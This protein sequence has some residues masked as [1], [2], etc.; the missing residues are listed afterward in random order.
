MITTASGLQYEVIKEGI[1]EKPG[2]NDK[3]T[4]HYH[5]TLPDGTVFDSSVDRNEPATFPVSG[6][7]A[8]WV[9]GLQLM[10][11]GSK[12]KFIIPANLAYGSRGAGGQIGP[13]QVLHFEVELIS[14]D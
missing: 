4:V 9:E 12:Y 13:N 3:V 10:S 5:G 14:I 7:I 6:V 1:G 8:G 11:E 2:P